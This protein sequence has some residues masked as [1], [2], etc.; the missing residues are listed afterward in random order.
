MTIVLGREAACIA[1][2][3]GR[4]AACIAPGWMLARGKPDNAAGVRSPESPVA[5]EDRGDLAA[6]LA[7]DGEAF[8][9]IV[10]RYQGRIAAQMRRFSRD[11]EEL[12]ELVQDVFVEAFRSLPSY[13]QRAPL[14]H[15]L[16]RIAT[17]VGYRFWKR[18]AKER[19]Q[20]DPRP[21]W[22]LGQTAAADAQE[23]SEAAELLHRLLGRLPPADRLVLTLLYFEQCSVREIAERTGWN[24]PLV[25]VRAFRARR[26]LRGLFAQ[27]G[28][29]R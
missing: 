17:R 23:P 29:R 15:W 26:K 11:P 12:E 8:G 22:I 1:P 20:R 24:R 16:R 18:Q 28:F 13:R 27:I 2:G 21:E 7:G 19:R 4:E 3:W 5:P 14:L 9:R 10:R 25:K 6:S